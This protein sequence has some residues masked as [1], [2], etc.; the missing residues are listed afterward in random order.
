[1][2]TSFTRLFFLLLIGLVSSISL[3]LKAQMKDS[4]VVLKIRDQYQKLG[5]AIA[6]CENEDDTPCGYYL[7]VLKTN[8]IGEPWPAVGTYQTEQKFWYSRDESSEVPAY[9]LHKIEVS[10]QRSAR[11]EHLEYLF[12][13]KGQLLFF[14]FKL[15]GD[16]ETSQ[17][18]RLYFENGMLETYKEKIGAK[19]LD[20][21]YYTK[22]DGRL[23]QEKAKRMMEKF[24]VMLAE[25]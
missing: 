19:E 1:M 10:I 23:I 3:N 21:A 9:T 7:N 18:F 12:D 4:Q 15:E 11:N 25:E 14:F 16:A 2:K 6:R 8:Q 5:E 22:D 17:A 24:K 20:Y 13:A